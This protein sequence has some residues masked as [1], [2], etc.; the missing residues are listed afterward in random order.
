MILKGDKGWYEAEDFTTKYS[1]IIKLAQLIVVQNV[2][3]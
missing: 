2:Y 3:M 1:A